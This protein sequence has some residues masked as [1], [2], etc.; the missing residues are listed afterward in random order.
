MLAGAG[1]GDDPRLAHSPGQQDLAQAI[2]DLVGAGVVQVFPLQEEAG[3]AQRF[4]D[5]AGIE[6]GAGPP[7]VI[8]QH[9]PVFAPERVV[10]QHVAIGLLQLIK[11]GDQGLGHVPAAILAELPKGVGGCGVR[12]KRHGVSPLNTLQLWY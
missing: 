8:R 4:G 5:R 9:R 7:D 11:R 1:L 12:S 2:V 10:V 3:A 6:E